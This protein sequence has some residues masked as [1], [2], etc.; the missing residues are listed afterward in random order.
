MMGTD[1]FPQPASTIFSV[2]PEV[3][4]SIADELKGARAIADIES[5]GFQHQL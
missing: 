5:E 4:L 1:P 2:G 3:I